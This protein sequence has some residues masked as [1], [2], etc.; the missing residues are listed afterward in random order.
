MLTKNIVE[1][2]SVRSRIRFPLP[3]FPFIPH[4]PPLVTCLFFYLPLS[5]SFSLFETFTTYLKQTKDFYIK[6]RSHVYVRT[7]SKLYTYLYTLRSYIPTYKKIIFKRSTFDQQ[8][9]N[10]YLISVSTTIRLLLELKFDES[11]EGWQALERR[12]GEEEDPKA[13]TRAMLLFPRGEP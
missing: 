4:L 9:N 2:L 11:I 1:L 6:A 12:T 13:V 3:P 5:L 10:R 7:F 8:Y